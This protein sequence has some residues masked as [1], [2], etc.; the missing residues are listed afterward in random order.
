MRKLGVDEWIIRILKSMYDSA[1]SRVRVNNSYSEPI[2][3]S[4]GVHQGS[5]L[6]PLLFII[7]MEALSFE[8]RVGFPWEL[9]YTDHLVIV[10]ESLDDLK[11][12]LETRKK[13]LEEKGLKVNVPKTKILC[14][15]HDSP[16][17]TNESVKFPCSVCSDGV[18]SN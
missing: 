6:G 14:S 18:G 9:L 11:L 16:K 4:V 3:V 2:H 10:S 15:S 7:V 17:T 5:V 1:Q 13:G 8:F 12:K